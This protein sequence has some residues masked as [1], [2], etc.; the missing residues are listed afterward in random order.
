M[1]GAIC[2]TTAT[3]AACVRL[4]GQL[5]CGICHQKC[6]WRGVMYVCHSCPGGQ[7]LETC[8]Y[9]W[10]A[11]HFQYLPMEWA[12]GRC[13]YLHTVALVD[14]RERGTCMHNGKGNEVVA[15]EGG[16]KQSKSEGVG[17]LQEE[18]LTACHPTGPTAMCVTHCTAGVLS[19]HHPLVHAV[20]LCSQFVCML[21]NRL[22]MPNM[23]A[24]SSELCLLGIRQK[25]HQCDLNR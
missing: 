18:S 23:K 15:G 12:P 7:L 17:M 11:E 8:K 20:V 3:T 13:L 14:T 24:C 1:A 16:G 4:A 9:S 5:Y 22:I 19:K 10:A 6:S 2:S 25:G 21:T